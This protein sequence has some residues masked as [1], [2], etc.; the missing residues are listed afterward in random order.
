MKINIYTVHIFPVLD[1]NFQLASRKDKYT[2]KN[3]IL[4]V[5]RREAYCV[6]MVSFYPITRYYPLA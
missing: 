1:L 4:R 3:E 5:T 2:A 6:E